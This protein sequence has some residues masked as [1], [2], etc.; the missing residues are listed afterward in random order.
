MKEILRKISNL[1]S[2]KNSSNKTVVLTRSMLEKKVD[3]GTA[4]AVK[5]YGEVFRKL[6]EYDRK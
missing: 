2:N 4:R 1:F 3:R 5:E 6:A